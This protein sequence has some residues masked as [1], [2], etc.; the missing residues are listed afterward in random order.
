MTLCEGKDLARF[1]HH[2]ILSTHCVAGTVLGTMDLNPCS[3][4]AYIL[5]EETD[6]S[7]LKQMNDMIFSIDEY[8]NK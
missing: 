7:H 1:I 5:V 8:F 3:H 4:G 2:Y 6:K